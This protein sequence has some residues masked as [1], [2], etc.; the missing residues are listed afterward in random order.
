MISGTNSRKGMAFFELAGIILA[1]V[2]FMLL[3]GIYFGN[4]FPRVREMVTGTEKTFNE[5][6]GTETQQSEV[7]LSE[8]AIT[9]KGSFQSMVTSIESCAQGSSKKCVCDLH[10]PE[11]NSKYVM[12]FRASSSGKGFTAYAFEGRAEKLNYP[13][14]MI[15]SSHYFKNLRFCTSED[16]LGYDVGELEK[17]GFVEEEMSNLYRGNGK[18]A[19]HHLPAGM[20]RSDGFYVLGSSRNPEKEPQDKERFSLYKVDD[21][22]VCFFIGRQGNEYRW[23]GHTFYLESSRNRLRKRIYELEQKVGKC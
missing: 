6:I 2:A 17:A 15:I 23:A 12:A 21:E 5:S 16:L 1:L 4:Q 10:I 3:A 7:A 22:H 8:E 18:L 9:L 14:K 11:F 20:L 19:F 13:N